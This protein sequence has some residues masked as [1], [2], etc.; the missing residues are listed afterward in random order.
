MTEK[1]QIYI[2]EEGV[3]RGYYVYLHKATETGEV[4]YVG[5]G[6]GRRAWET[7]KRNNT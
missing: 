6:S 5:K 7:K 2:D 1:P 3:K 4:F